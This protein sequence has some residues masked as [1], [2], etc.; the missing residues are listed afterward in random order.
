MS[1]LS[2]RGTAVLYFTSSSFELVLHY[3]ESAEHT[4]RFING[5]IGHRRLPFAE[6]NT[7]A[8]VEVG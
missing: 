2:R 4:F 6:P 7:R 5:S 3:P 8:G 1:P